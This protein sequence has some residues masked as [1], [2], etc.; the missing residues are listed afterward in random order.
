M[1]CNFQM[2]RLLASRHPE[3]VGPDYQYQ[4]WTAKTVDGNPFWGAGNFCGL[5]TGHVIRYGRELTDLEWDGNELYVS[6]EDAPGQA[7][8]IYRS[9][10]MQ[11]QEKFPDTEFD[12]M[13]SG[14]GIIM[15]MQN[16]GHWM[17]LRKRLS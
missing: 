2:E 13:V 8:A 17:D 9:I 14:T 5:D 15:W 10:K 12:L 16:A 11:L 6:G 1:I 7:F 3:D 4:V